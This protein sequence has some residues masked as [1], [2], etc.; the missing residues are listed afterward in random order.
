HL[1]HA[2]VAA[3]V[4]I[5]QATLAAVIPAAIAATAAPDAHL[6]VAGVD[7]LAEAAA[8]NLAGVGQIG[9]ERHHQ[10]LLAAADGSDQTAVAA[11]EADRRIGAHAG[12]APHLDQLADEVAVAPVVHVRPVHHRRARAGEDVGVGLAD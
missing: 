3:K 9:V 8:G 1:R 11:M 6:A 5:D 4:H 7:R 2:V 10:G 12:G